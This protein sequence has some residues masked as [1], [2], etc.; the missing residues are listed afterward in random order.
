MAVSKKKKI[1]I[2]SVAAVVVIGG[3]IGMSVY[4]RRGDLPEVQ[5][6]KVEKRALLESKVTAN[7]EVRPIQFINLTA[8]VAGRVTDVYVTEGQQVTK[9]KPLV[10]VDP[11]QIAS[12]TSVQEAALRAN[13]AEV[14]NQSAV[15]AATE[16]SI[17]SAR[18]AL[19]S[20]Q[21]D[22]E[23]AKV[24]RNIA[25]VEMKRNADLVESNIVAR[26]VYDAAKARYDS[27]D[28]S[29][30]AA[31]ARV[32]QS[33]VQVKDAEIRV[34]QAKASLASAQARVAQAQASLRSQ[35]DL[36]S[37]TTQYA[38]INGVVVGPLVQVG[39]FALANFQSTPLMII[40][41]MSVI[42][43]E[44]R[45]DETD[46]ANVQLGQKAKV[47]VDALGERELNGEVVE[48][49]ASAVT[50]TG[51]TI[52]QTTVAG[53]QEAKDFKVVVRLDVDDETR[54]RLRP[55]MSATATIGT[56]KRENVIAIP[57]QA[58]VERDP[59]QLDGPGKP[60][61][62]SPAPSP[63]ASPAGGQGGPGGKDKKAQKGVFLVK[64]GKAV[65]TPVETGI[66]GENDIEIKSGL[67]GGE[68][69]ITGPYRQLRNLK[70]NAPVKLEDKSK[71][72]GGGG[73]NRSQ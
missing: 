53:S 32:N 54:N 45:V 50:R 16:N 35:S 20:A 69:L 11:T 44:V 28:A 10:R 62:S 67:S 2:A 15:I 23:R 55:G 68:E 73:E 26:T 34:N 42:N 36:L 27:A 21:A 71:R 1:V 57:L 51:Q 40:A 56:D 43:V 48:K 14:Q 17:G 49:A 52:A 70:N 9:G 12:Q 24:E 58:L 30:K 46:I 38:T 65:F 33:Q 64:N 7:G 8:E 60:G 63:A 4:A 59:S 13:Q 29:V 6:A 3:I 39:T 37:K 72:A 61:A 22:L 31:E 5:T 18:A 66:T 19:L 25:E 41:D 47:K